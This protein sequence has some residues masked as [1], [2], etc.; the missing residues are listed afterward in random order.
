[1]KKRVSLFSA[2]CLFILLGCAPLLSQAQSKSKLQAHAIEVVQDDVTKKVVI[3]ADGKPFTQLI[4][5]DTLEKHFLY[6]IYA[7][8]GHII[9]RGYPFAPRPNEPDDHPHHTGLWLNYESVNGLDFWNNS[10]AIPADRKHKYGWIKP[11]KILKAKGGKKDGEVRILSTWQNQKG[12]TLLDE[13]STFIFRA[14]AGK[15]VIDR[16]TTLTAKTDVNM[17]DIKDGMLGLRLAHELEMPSKTKKEFTDDKGNVT[18]VDANADTAPSGN[19]LTSEGTEG[20]DV[21]GT[22]AQ[23]CMI[24]GKMGSDTAS[25][26]IIDHPR[27][28]GYPTYW[29]ARGY[30]L[31]SANPLGQKV[32]SN[33]KETLNFALK[34]GQ[35]VTFR[36]RVVIATG[37]QRLSN[38]EIGLIAGDFY[39]TVK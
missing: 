17:P 25:V 33:G 19:Y 16:I 10:F 28:V 22:R 29:H 2:H 8:G 34:Q 24:Y 31:F 39:Q 37:A 12:Q 5:T 27:N 20:D 3:T 23:W 11:V 26:V 38:D 15:R 36:H 18:V 1:M 32:F 14:D 13:T 6:P 35:S 9:T 7:P 21:W 4:Y 30:G